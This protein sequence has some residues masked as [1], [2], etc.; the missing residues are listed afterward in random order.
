MQVG[1]G[2]CCE[3]LEGVSGAQGDGNRFL[4]AKEFLVP[5]VP[6]LARPVAIVED[7][8]PGAVAGADG[9]EG[10][11]DDFGEPDFGVGGLEDAF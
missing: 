5:P 10:V 11:F 3:C 6:G 9:L 2:D 1:F 8:F 7:E 4:A